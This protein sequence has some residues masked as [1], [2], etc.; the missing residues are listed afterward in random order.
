MAG[1]RVWAVVLGCA[2]R[3]RAVRAAVQA[4]AAGSC[5]HPGPLLASAAD[6]SAGTRCAD[7][8]HGLVEDLLLRPGCL[9]CDGWARPGIVQARADRLEILLRTCDP[10]LTTDSPRT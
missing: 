8:A 1:E 7:C 4:R 9:L 5:G 2:V 3:E 6:P 10:C